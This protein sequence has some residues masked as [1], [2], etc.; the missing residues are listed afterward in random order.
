MRAARRAFAVTGIALVLLSAC[1]R[2]DRPPPSLMNIRSNEGPDEFAIVPPKA[3]S[4]PESLTDL[5][6]PTPGG[7]NLTDVTPN[8][9]AVVA[10]GGR[11][12]GGAAGDAGLIGHIS[13]YGVASDIRATLA[14]DDLAFRSRNKGRPLERLFNVNVYYRVY[15]RQSLNQ[16]RE[17]ERWRAA[18]AR[19]V[20]AP[21]PQR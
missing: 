4:L 19:T 17:L 2:G 20:S 18:G 1:G 9:D 11:P 7:T 8:A 5:P 16:E 14:A 21:P 15:E 6:E 10:L 3:L 12:D 13:R